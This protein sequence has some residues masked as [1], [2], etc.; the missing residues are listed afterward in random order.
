MKKKPAQD[1]VFDPK[2]CRE[3][4]TKF[5][6]HAEIPFLKFEDP[7]LQVWIDSMQPAFQ[8]KGRHTVRDDAMKMYQEMKKD[9]EIEFENLDSRICLTS[10]MWTSN[11]NLGYMCITAHYIDAGFNYKK[12]IINFKEVRYP[13]TGFA[14]EEAIVSCLTEWGIRNKIFTMTLDN[15]N[16]NTTACEEFV[17]YHKNEL[18]LEG[19]NLHVRC[20]A[21]IL[22]IL[23]QDGMKII[24]RSINKIR[25]LL[26]HIETSPTRLQD[27]NTI[28]IA[29]GL[30]SKKGMCIDVANRWNSTWKM[31]VQALVYRSVLDSYASQHLQEYPIEEEW[32]RAKG[33]CDFLKAFEEL[34]LTVSAHRKPTSHQFLPVVLCIRHALKDPAW[35]TSEVLKELASV[36]QT[37]LDKYWDPNEKD[38]DQNRRRKS[39]EIELNPALVIATFLDPR[40]KAN[41]LDF[42]YSKVCNSDDQVCNHVD[43][44]IDMVKKYIREYEQLAT[45]GTAYSTPSSQGGSIIVG[46]P[47][48]GKRK[49]EEE[50]A[51]YRSRRRTTRVQRSELDTYLE[52]ICEV[53]MADFDVLNW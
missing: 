51:Q 48:V 6:I 47:I 35:Q 18:L 4:M 17:K 39:K 16:N 30:A 1:F 10:D 11:Q 9:I 36:M 24:H 23:V 43:A 27:F 40:R 45:T 22:N 44:A 21:H 32:A 7:Y 46:S 52:E 41:Y 20:C 49:L 25:E 2:L 19:Q 33:I 8:I 34:T 31:L 13:H 3:L 14:I 26:K 50:F 29:M 38:V 15:A 5:C 42:F 53:D 37:K 28:A 12:K